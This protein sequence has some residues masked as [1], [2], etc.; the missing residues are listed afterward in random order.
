MQT[1]TPKTLIDDWMNAT[2]FVDNLS[3]DV[4]EDD[5]VELFSCVGPVR[6]AELE[7]QRTWGELRLGAW[8]TMGSPKAAAQAVRRCDGRD[9]FGKPLAV[10]KVRRAA[11]PVPPSVH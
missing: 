8:V 1:R 10:R 5:V 6:A 4:T 11:G 3:L 2:V 9:L 7:F